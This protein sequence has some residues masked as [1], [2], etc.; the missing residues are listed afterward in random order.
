ML[1]ADV[2][3]ICL[4]LSLTDEASL[5]SNYFFFF[6]LSLTVFTH[7]LTA[8]FVSLQFICEA[9]SASA[10]HRESHAQTVKSICL[11]RL[12]LYNGSPAAAAS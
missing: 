11:S 4:R 1:S 9:T 6:S 2:P 3:D 10:L 7:F 12:P 5:S 8:T